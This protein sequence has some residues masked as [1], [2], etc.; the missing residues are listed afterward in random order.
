MQFLRLIAHE[1]SLSLA[2]AVLL[3]MTA[4]AAR[5]ADGAAALGLPYDLSK[6]RGME[7]LPRDEHVRALLSTHGFVILPREHRQIFSP[8]LASFEAAYVPPFVTV[9][10]AVRTYQVMLTEGFRSLER[11]Q[12]P[13]LAAISA[14]LR[15]DIGALRLR[16]SPWREA[17]DRLEAWAAVGLLLQ[18]EKADLG[19]LSEGSR[20]LAARER[21]LIGKGEAAESAIFGRG[22]PFLFGHLAPAGFYA[23][24]PLLADY[25]RAVKWY[26]LTSFRVRENAELPSALLLAWCVRGDP[27]LRDLLA[28]FSAPFDAL[29]GPPDDI[30]LREA[31]E[32]L[33]ALPGAPASLDVHALS[34]ALPEFGKKMAAL[35]LPRVNDQVLD[36]VTYVSAADTAT[37]GLRLLPARH[38][39]E[40]EFGTRIGRLEVK[41]RLE[42]S[43]LHVVLAMGDARA[44]ELL[45]RKRTATPA[46]IARVR[47]LGS[48]TLARSAPA[49]YKDCVET[50]A[51]I[52]A[53][54]PAEA[55]AFTRT[56]AW[57]TACTLSGLGGW[58]SIRHQF[59]LHAKELVVVFGISEEPPRP[60]GY[61]APYPHVF[62]KL[63]ALSRK[64]HDLLDR[65]GAFPATTRDDEEGARPSPGAVS[66]S[67]GRFA[68]L[69]D[70]IAAIAEKQLRD[71]ALTLAER[72]LL[73]RYGGR[74]SSLH[75]YSDPLDEP[76][77][78][79]P[80]AV[81]FATY[82]DESIP[83]RFERYA[84]IGRAFE[85]F[86]IRPAPPE[87]VRDVS[88]R[89]VVE[90]P[91]A[92]QLY[93]GGVFSFYEWEKKVTTPR[94][95]DEEWTQVLDGEAFRG[96]PARLPAWAADIAFPVEPGYR[97]RARAGILPAGSGERRPTIDEDPGL[98][99]AALEGYSKGGADSGRLLGVFVDCT[100]PEDADRLVDIAPRIEDPLHLQSVACEFAREASA[101]SKERLFAA[102]PKGHPNLLVM[103]LHAV[104]FG[105]SAERL[106]AIFGESEEGRW[107][108][109]AALG[110]V[111]EAGAFSRNG[112]FFDASPPL[113]AGNGDALAALA[114][115]DSSFLV[116]AHAMSSL[117]AAPGEKALPVLRKGLADPSPAVRT[118]AGLSL[119]ALDDTQSYPEIGR[120]LRG[121]EAPSIREQVCA[122][123]ERMRKTRMA[124]EDRRGE[125][126]GGE[127]GYLFAMLL[128]G[129]EEAGWGGAPLPLADIYAGRYVSDPSPRAQWAWRLREADP[130]H[131]REL[132]VALAIDPERSTGYRADVIEGLDGLD[133][134]M[135]LAARLEPLLGDETI[136]D[137]ETGTRLCDMA[138]AIVLSGV[139]GARMVPIDSPGQRRDAQ[140]RARLALAY[141]ARLPEENMEAIQRDRK[142]GS[143]EEEL[144]P[145][146]EIGVPGGMPPEEVDALIFATIGDLCAG[147][148]SFFDFD[149]GVDDCALA[150]EYHSL[151]QLHG[152]LVSLPIGASLFVGGEAWPRADE[153]ITI[154]EVELAS[155]F[156]AA[157]GSGSFYLDPVFRGSVTVEC[158]CAFDFIGECAPEFTLCARS[159][160]ERYGASFGVRAVR[161]AGGEAEGGRPKGF[162]L[163][164]SALPQALTSGS[165]VTMRVELRWPEGAR[166]G[167]LHVFFAGQEVSVLDGVAAAHGRVGLSWSNCYFVLRRLAVRGTLD[168]GWAV[169]ALYRKA[170][171]KL[172]GAS[173]ASPS[174]D[175]R[176]RVLREALNQAIPVS[177]K[178]GRPVFR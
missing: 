79:M 44:A 57:G 165:P 48:E 63:G 133:L 148:E 6:V 66:G 123:G 18:D 125:T 64:T 31:A 166:Q 72:D 172:G 10:S 100:R 118:F 99:D 47:E 22:E 174:D 124:L 126:A 5:A 50:L 92:L 105:T 82:S 51:G 84:A 91:A 151:G 24:E 140:R 8:Y 116:R 90:I 163:E 159:D 46:T 62:R 49:L 74:L 98:A 26:E 138:A 80:Q 59:E 28:E 147:L 146:D 153:T 75:F 39:W 141:A 15:A 114:S 14:R 131:Y 30:T 13:R 122:E 88:T 87:R 77:D 45:R 33:D 56:D 89:R 129:L 132:A 176:A 134:S 61:V 161:I 67:F 27:E 158:D 117:V 55:P 106:R 155:P 164:R 102:A 53:P 25:Y 150:L 169:E 110:Y 130:D 175:F 76:K 162:S 104:P 128:R 120:V 23:D 68:E 11:A 19:V 60:S 154:G 142:E 139:E 36:L 96:S 121:L 97:A 173:L 103:A 41:P 9:D 111:P 43:P 54:L 35:R 2:V 29:L 38:T 58:V 177:P 86:V 113:P 52:F 1:R 152:D 32:A 156:L 145:W 115:G 136:V 73:E 171:R 17:K 69:M 21:E 93:R 112:E 108:L 71:E 160:E 143:R 12:A 85:I 4:R 95:T 137:E 40:A 3:V 65:C 135:S 144:L 34:A 16:D 178:S 83:L 94:L 157:G 78:D 107:V 109:A 37:Q 101:S 119:V 81:L 42:F 70:M 127:D 170:L 167:S 7:R 168:R 149:D 20:T